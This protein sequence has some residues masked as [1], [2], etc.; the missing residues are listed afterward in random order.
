M[1]AT[2]QIAVSCFVSCPNIIQIVFCYLVDEFYY[3]V[4]G[5]Q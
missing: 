3:I 4:A 2:H 5:T 1:A